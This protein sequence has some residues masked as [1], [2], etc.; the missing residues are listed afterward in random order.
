MLMLGTPRAKDL[1]WMKVE[2]QTKL[3]A[4]P[5]LL[6]AHKTLAFSFPC[7]KCNCLSHA[8]GMKEGLLNSS[9]GW[10]SLNQ[11]RTDFFF[12]KSYVTS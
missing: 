2:S 8:T 12:M 7:S 6:D 1:K 9:P 4:E 10:I 5:V 3:S 11:S